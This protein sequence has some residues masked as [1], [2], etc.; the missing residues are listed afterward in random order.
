MVTC[1]IEAKQ[2][3]RKIAVLTIAEYCNLSCVYCFETV[4]TQKAMPIEVAKAAVDY[5]FAHSDGYD[6]IEF[7]LFGGEPTLNWEVVRELVEWT[8]VQAYNM[9]FVFFLET[10]GTLVHGNIQQWLIDHKDHVS[11]GLSLDGTP[12]THNRNRS[13][14][15]D[16]IDI[17]FF[18]LHYPEQSVRMTVNSSTVGNLF[19]DIVH[20]HTLGFADVEATF[21]H[22]IT[23]ESDRI[24]K[25]LKEELGKLCNYYLDHPEIAECS[26]FDMPLPRLLRRGPT[27]Q[28]WCGTGKSMT[29]Y[30]VDGKRYPCHTFQS[31]TTSASNAVVLGEIDFERIDDFSDPEC[32]RCILETVCPNCYGMNYARNGAILKRDKGLCG[33]S[34]ARALAISYLRAR[35]IEKDPKRMPP[36]ETY[37]T[38]AAIAAI[39]N[40]FSTE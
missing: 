4:K 36:N 24:D 17:G 34:K 28:Q 6:E 26:I 16:Q 40:E 10:N 35:Q 38:I 30:G 27:I 18:L 22:G 8:V 14:S 37:Q 21:A 33:I 19:Q 1:D 25:D 20:L 12:E 5:E 31:N 7:D 29:S 11:A 39:Q 15:Y 32:S 2:R 3:H 13:N 23:W 9:P